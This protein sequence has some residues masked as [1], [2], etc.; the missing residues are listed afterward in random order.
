LNQAGLGTLQ[1]D[2]YAAGDIRGGGRHLAADPAA[3]PQVPAGATVRAGKEVRP[4][5]G[6]DTSIS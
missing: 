5:A 4:C 2:L 6:R 3:Q 1:A